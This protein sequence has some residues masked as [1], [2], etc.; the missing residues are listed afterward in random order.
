MNKHS[1]YLSAASKTSKTVSIGAIALH[2]LEEVL[3]LIDCFHTQ[4]EFSNPYFTVQTT[5][6]SLYSI[7]YTVQSI[8]ND[9]QVSMDQNLSSPYIKLSPQNVILCY[10][11]QVSCASNPMCEIHFRH[12]SST[13]ISHFHFKNEFYSLAQNRSIFVSVLIDCSSRF[14]R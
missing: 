10:S 13:M 7:D 11:F 12:H 6:F 8:L 5:L 3:N 2:Q 1:L 14:H 4:T 9:H